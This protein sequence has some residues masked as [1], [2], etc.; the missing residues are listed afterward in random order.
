MK[1]ETSHFFHSS[2]NPFCCKIIVN[3]K[4]MDKKQTNENGMEHPLILAGLYFILLL[5]QLLLL[6]VFVNIIKKKCC[7]CTAPIERGI[8]RKKRTFDRVEVVTF[9]S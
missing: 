1:R 8:E 7:S 6:L 2:S 5:L 9:L 4:R 3:A